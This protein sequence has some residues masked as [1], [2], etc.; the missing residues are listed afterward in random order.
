[1]EQFGVDGQI[2]HLSLI[3]QH[4]FPHQANICEYLDVILEVTRSE[5]TDVSVRPIWPD[6]MHALSLS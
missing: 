3:P 2:W 4:L 6:R 5:Q 1:M